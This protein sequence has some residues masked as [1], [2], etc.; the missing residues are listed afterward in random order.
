MRRDEVDRIEEQS[1]M[2]ER[3]KEAAAVDPNDPECRNPALYRR[4][5]GE[6]PYR[7]FLLLPQGTFQKQRDMERF[8]ERMR[9]LTPAETEME[10][11]LLKPCI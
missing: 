1:L 11:V 5:Y 4:L 6:E 8:L 9:R 3:K 10:L 2:E 7:F